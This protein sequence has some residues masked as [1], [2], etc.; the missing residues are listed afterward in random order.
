MPARCVVA[1]CSN[2]TQDGVSLF[3]FPKD[4]H[5]RSLW[6]RFVRMKRADW[7]GGHDRSLIC[8]AHFT[9]ECFDISSVTQKKLEFG[10]RLLLTKTA[11]PTLNVYPSMNGN[12]QSISQPK[13]RGAFRKKIIEEADE[14]E[15]EPQP[16]AALQPPVLPEQTSVQETPLPSAEASLQTVLAAVQAVERKLDS[17]ATRLLGLEGRMWM[18]EKKLIGC[19]RTVVEFGNQ[20]ESKWAVLGTL[21]QEYGLLQRRLE[22]MENLLKNRNFWIL[23]LPPGTNGEVPK[24]PVTFDDISVYF[25]EQE[26][27]SLNEWQKEL[28]KN[29]IKGNYETLISLDYAVSKPDILSRIER[30]EEPYIGDLQDS[31]ERKISTEPCVI[32]GCDVLSWIK[33]EEQSCAEDQEH[34]GEGEFSTDPYTGCQASA[35]YASCR[36]DIEEE[37]SVRDMQV[38][39]ERQIH[40]ELCADHNKKPLDAVAAKEDLAMASTKKSNLPPMIDSRFTEKDLNDVFTFEFEN[41]KSGLLR[42]AKKKS[43]T[44]KVE[45]EVNGELKPCSFK[46]SEASAVKSFNLW[47]HVKRNHPED[48]AALVTKKDQEDEAKQKADAAKRR[49]SG[50]LKTPGEKIFCGASSEKKP[51]IEQTKFDSYLKSSKVTVTMDANTF[52]EGL[53]E[54]VCLSSTPL[55]T[56]RLKNKG[57]QKISGEMGQ[58]LGVS[59][60]HDAVRHLV[61]STAESGRQELKKAL[62]QKLCYLKMDAATRGNRHFLA[63]NAQYY[64]EGKDKAV[65]KTL[66]VIDTEGCHNSLYVKNQVKA[67]LEKFGISEMQVLSICVDNAANMTCAVKNFSEDNETISTSENRDVDRSE[68]ILPDESTKGMDEIELNM[69]A[70]AQWVNDPSLIL[71]TWLHEDDSK[72]QLMR[73]GIH[74]LQLAIWDGLNKEHAKEFL[75]KIRQV[76]VK[77]RTPSIQSVLLDLHGVTQSLDTV[78]RWGSTFAMIDRLLVFQSYCEQVAAAAGTREF[79]LTKAEWDEVKNLRDLLAK[80]NQTIVN[81]QAA[82]VTPGVLMKEW[83]KLSKFLQENGGQIA[84]GILSSMQKREE[85]LFDNIHFLAGVYVDPRYR[86]LLTSREIPKAKEGLLDIARRLEKQ[87][88]LL[89][90]N[91]AKEVE[92]NKTQQKGSSTIEFAVSE[93]SHP[94]EI[95]GCSQTSVSTLNLFKRPSLRRLQPSQGNGDNSNTSSS[96][97]DAFEKELDKE[98]RRRQVSAIHN[99]NEALFERNFREDCEAMESIGRLKVKTVFE[100][101]HSYPHRIQAACRIASSM[102]TTQASVERLFSALKLILNDMRQGVKDDLIAAIIFYRM[103]YE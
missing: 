54:M 91:S 7:R 65:V 31:E 83:R 69:D 39:E 55:T 29:T 32:F 80:P 47:R 88:L 8:S 16:L 42:K 48:Y 59:T 101:I 85:K 99:C 24:V 3:K 98:D 100:A 97:D 45:K 94:S 92:E 78:T 76:V 50:S 67:V 61:V 74:T 37:P 60:G 28:Y 87:N 58:Q 33:L 41:P 96:E 68:A 93:S 17:H 18:A 38:S 81:L 79:K 53:M 43:A 2:T 72:V 36:R 19:E 52:R 84:E 95:A 73:C 40:T 51:K 13:G 5:V 20:L 12:P 103:N 75:A 15:V 10:K 22:N 14:W 49:P 6:D 35:H 23:R 34:F 26:W 27:K 30:G 66:D 46:T 62:E 9:D 90:L 56:F 11:V 71:P 57:F 102:P 82:D 21:I 25:N 89:L 70:A 64:E 44:C 1:R 77:L 4:P 63:I 86:I